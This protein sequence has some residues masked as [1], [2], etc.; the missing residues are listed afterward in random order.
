MN[1]A[2]ICHGSLDLIQKSSCNSF[3]FPRHPKSSSPVRR[4]ESFSPYNSLLFRR[5]LGERKLLKKVFGC[6]GLGHFPTIQMYPTSHFRS[7]G[8]SIT[9][10]A[11]EGYDNC[12]KTGDYLVRGGW[13]RMIHVSFFFVGEDL[14]I[15]IKACHGDHNR[16]NRENGAMF[17]CVFTSSRKIC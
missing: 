2:S 9:W 8:A 10:C 15:Y 13:G 3:S 17:C 14:Y 11:S 1:I 6:I 7:A 12:S 4:C 16:L 5:C